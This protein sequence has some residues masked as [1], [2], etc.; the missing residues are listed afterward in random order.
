MLL[1][2]RSSAADPLNLRNP[3]LMMA[4]PDVQVDHATVHRWTSRILPVLDS[5]FRQRKSSAGL[6][7]R[8]DEP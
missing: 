4:E 6:S 5:V 2:V 7:W 3:V 8:D 1:C